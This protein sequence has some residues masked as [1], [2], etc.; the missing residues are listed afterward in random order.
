MIGSAVEISDQCRSLA[1]KVGFPSAEVPALDPRGYAIL[2][3]YDEL[4]AS[5]SIDD[6]IWRRDPDFAFYLAL[7]GSVAAYSVDHNE[8]VAY[9]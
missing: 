7:F 4:T 3:W 5:G 1:E 8:A 6:P 2:D 9:C